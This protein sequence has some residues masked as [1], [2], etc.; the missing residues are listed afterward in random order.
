MPLFRWSLWNPTPQLVEMLEASVGT[1]RAYFGRRAEYVVFVDETMELTSNI[2]IGAEIVRYTPS[3][4]RFW[5]GHS[6]WR[7]WAPSFRINPSD[8]EVYVDLD[9]F[10][11]DNPVELLRFIDG[12]GFEYVITYEEFADA[13][14][15][16]LFARR[17][18]NDFI[19]VN[20]GLVGQRA[21]STFQIEFEKEYQ[22]WR[23]QLGEVGVEPHHHD[24]QGAVAYALQS[25][26]QRGSVQVLDPSR[27]RILCPRNMANVKDVSGIAGIHTTDYGH[28]AYYENRQAIWRVATGR[29]DDHRSHREK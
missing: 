5:D 4:A 25:E 9:F 26:I 24:E 22:W 8:T 27:Y 7:K 2:S 10:L 13:A 6:T 29:G 15:Y 12:N 3:S 1:F 19:P 11:L 21:G 14:P 17:I 16:G 28:P 20:S 23:T 18:R